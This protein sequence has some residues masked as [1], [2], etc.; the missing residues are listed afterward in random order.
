MTRS[1]CR[2]YSLVELLMAMGLAALVGTIILPTV[3]S[4]QTRGLAEVS[5]GELQQRAERLLRFLADDV[6]DA[7]FMT[8]AQ[9]RTPVGS[10]P[11]LVHDSLPGDPAESVAAALLAA[12]GGAAGEDLL[13]VAK[14]ESFFPLLRF[15]GPAGAGATRLVLDRRPNQSPGSS[16]EIRPAPE[17]ISHVVPA[18]HRSCYP[19]AGISG[20]FV[21]L[22]IP[23]AEEV[24]TGTELLGLRCYRYLLEPFAGGQRLRRDDF[25]SSEILDDAV[26]GLQFQYLLSDGRF[27]D[28]PV[29]LS[30]VRAVRILLLVRDLRP[31]REY[32]DEARYPLGNRVY[33]PFADSFRRLAVTQVVEV[34]NH[35]GS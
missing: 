13:T 7:A 22:A 4:V 25:T 23:L 12:D 16:R 28:Q 34:K 11:V 35:G 32:R 27:V 19:V 6:R 17:A 20:T 33:G 31:D 26:D 9:P 24:P 1:G 2:G 15:A 3:L 21:D 30:T 14:A 10:A 29:D 18:S 5:R 8:G